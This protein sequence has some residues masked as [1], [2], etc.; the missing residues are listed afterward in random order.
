[1]LITQIVINSSIKIIRHYIIM[2][3]LFAQGHN[4]TQKKKKDREVGEG[5]GAAGGKIEQL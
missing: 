5:D 1:M 2:Y 4:Q 3:I